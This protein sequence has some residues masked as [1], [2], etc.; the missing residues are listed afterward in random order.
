MPRYMLLAKKIYSAS[1]DSDFLI[2]NNKKIEEFGR[3][4]FKPEN[5]S[6]IKKIN[7]SRYFIFPGFIDSH[8]HFI[9]TGL[10]LSFI[11]L[12]DISSNKDVIERLASRRKS[13]DWVI[14]YGYDENKVKEK[15]RITI[16]GLDKI[17]KE[18]KFAVIRIDYHSILL[19]SKALD[20]VNKLLNIKVKHSS[21][22]IKGRSISSVYK[23]IYENTSLEVKIKAVKDAVNLALS[24][25]LTTVHALEGGQFS[26]NKDIEIL[27][28]IKQRFPLNI[29]IYPQTTNVDWVKKRGFSRIGGCILVDGSFGSRTAALSSPYNDDPENCGILYFKYRNLYKFIEKAHRHELQVALHAIGDRAI[30]QAVDCMYEVV[31]IHGPARFNHRLEHFEL[32]GR[33]SIEKAKKSRIC[34]S[35]QPAFEYFW[36]GSEKMYYKRLGDRIRFTNPLRTLIKGGFLIAGGSDSDVTPINPLLG[37]HSAVNHPNHEERLSLTDAVKLFTENGAKIAYLEN[38][39]KI[40]KGFMADL[41]VLNKNPFEVKGDKIKNIEVVATIT[42]G[43]VVYNNKKYSSGE[44]NDV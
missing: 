12:N 25:G 36:G 28:E 16:E 43:N 39:G 8:T 14:A 15:E 41:V 34:L 35:M 27:N 2:V 37:I 32:P 18:C 23:V 20:E 42:E 10:N 26:A 11:S 9:H 17:N 44:I 29:V 31:K 7:F 6:R 19:S 4:D 21:G 3:Y 24:R 40:K 1:K 30:K 5:I 38:R 13:K 33:E 22:W